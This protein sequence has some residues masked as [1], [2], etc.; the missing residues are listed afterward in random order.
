[1]LAVINKAGLAR[2]R[3][4]GAV[5]KA[6]DGESFEAFY[7]CNEAYSSSIVLSI[8][9]ALVGVTPSSAVAVC[10]GTDWLCLVDGVCGDVADAT[11]FLEERRFLVEAQAERNPLP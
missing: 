3:R 4:V 10:G 9:N 7:R 6:D 5:Y 8:Q 11:A 2:V 1:M